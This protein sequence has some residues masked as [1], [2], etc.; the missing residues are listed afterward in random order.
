MFWRKQKKTSSPVGVES[1]AFETGMPKP[2]AEKLPGP[3]GIPEAIGRYLVAELK[4]NPDWIWKLKG[5]L[6]PRTDGKDRF[7]FRLFNKAQVKEKEIV[8]RNYTSLDEYPDL[9]IYQ[10]WFDKKSM[11]VELE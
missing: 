6:C 10:G 4:Q 9:I 5:V 2:K 11:A 7:N 8:I 1:A 3:K